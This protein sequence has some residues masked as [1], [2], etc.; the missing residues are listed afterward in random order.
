VLLSL[1]ALREASNQTLLEH[2]RAIAAIIP[3]IDFTFSQQLEGV[4][5]TWISGVNLPG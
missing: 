2:C 3:V 5:W 1:A 4:N